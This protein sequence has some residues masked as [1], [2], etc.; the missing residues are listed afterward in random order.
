MK[1]FPRAPIVRILHKYQIYFCC[2]E[3]KLLNCN[4]NIYAETVGKGGDARIDL[5]SLTYISP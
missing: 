4:R 2:E 5:G 3:K 1:I